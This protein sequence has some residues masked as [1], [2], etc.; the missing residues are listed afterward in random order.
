MTE[1]EIS[2]GAFAMPMHNPAYPLPPYRL[3]D[4]EMLVIAYRCNR[5]QLARI[6]PAPLKLAE[7]VVYFEFIRL[8]DSTGFGPYCEASQAIPVTFDG[9]RG[10]Y[11]HASYLSNHVSMAAGRELW[12]FPKKLGRPELR[13]CKDTL[14]GT[15]DHG[16]LRVATGTMGYKHQPA[17]ERA[18]REMVEVPT[19]VLKIIPHVDGRP[20]ICELV[21]CPVAD[22]AISGAWRA[23]GAL[24]L[25][26]HALVPVAELPVG[27][28]VSAL[29]VQAD[30]TLPT[31]EVVHD[32]MTEALVAN[33]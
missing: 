11:L 4:C 26:S 14:V 2:A 32:Y 27:E 20:R 17:D 19:F 3:V 31:G 7:P 1:Q 33:A 6:V 21:R 12:G 18:V 24:E 22:L 23:P 15:L 29:H 28:V 10:R 16:G 8:P 13:V 5:E 25:H 30:L 9:E